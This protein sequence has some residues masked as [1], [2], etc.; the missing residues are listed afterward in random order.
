TMYYDVNGNGSYQ[1]ATDIQAVVRTL[2][3][4]GR[5]YFTQ[6]VT[7]NPPATNGQ[8]LRWYHAAD[9]FLGGSDQG[10]AY[11]LA[12]GVGSTTSTTANTSV[13]ATRRGFGTA[14]E[15]FVGFAEV[16]GGREWDRYYSGTYNG[17]GLYSGGMAGG[18]NIV[19][20]IDTNTATDNGLG[21]QFNLGTLTAPL[22]FSYNLVF[23]S[24]TSLDLDAN[25]S[26]VAGNN[27]SGSYV[28]GSGTPVAIADADALVTNVAGD[29][30]SVQVRITNFQTGD[31][32]SVS[33]ALPAGITASAYNPAT[34]IITLSGSATEAAYQTA[35]TQMRFNSTSA[36]STAR[37]VQFTLG[38]EIS[39]LTATAN[40]TIR[41]NTPPVAV[42][43]SFNTVHDT[44]VTIN[45]RANDSDPNG[46]AIAVSKVNGTS[47]VAGGPGVA[48]TGGMVTLVS[49]NLVFTPTANYAG[50]P[51]FTYTI[52][53][54]NGGEATATV[55]GTVSNIPPF[56][57]LDGPT[58]P[59]NLLTN[60]GFESGTTT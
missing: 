42:A 56:V 24:D 23:D 20:T 58:T 18:G 2:Y 39:S 53:D 49:G 1:A 9:T 8:A 21:V 54:A 60:G 3:V 15:V 41:M 52:A 25:N 14:S 10:P 22:T 31:T 44:A 5:K 12:T 26:T 35:I 4:S 30:A 47:I 50:T 48:V 36:V 7:I 59:P 28:I 37:T 32:L 33:G 29:I 13:I 11:A 46:D 57:D 34:G 55:N 27:Y 38:N 19:N 51:S 17:A 16:Q 6:E 40:A 43:D 45:V